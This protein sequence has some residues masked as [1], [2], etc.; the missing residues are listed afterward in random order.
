M[1]TLIAA[2]ALGVATVVAGAA[3]AAEIEV[4]ML[5]KGEKAAMVFQP[6]FVKA[7][8]GDTIRFVPTDKGHNVEAIKGMLP[9]GAEPFKS[10]FNEEF[11]VTLDK[12][13]V[14]GVK[15]SPHYGMGMVALIEVGKPVN[16]EEAKAI[17]QTGKAKTVFA[18]LFGQVVAAN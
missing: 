5:N 13:G 16:I 2:L 11:T 15:C 17:K 18:G 12:E 9:E 10:K 4:V 6:D 14:Y 8:P 7:A 1:K 3:G